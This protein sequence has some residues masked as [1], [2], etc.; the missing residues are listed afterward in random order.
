MIHRASDLAAFA[1]ALLRAAGL[2]GDRTRV[3][4]EVLVEADLLGHTTHGLDML[5]PYLGDLD[6]GRMARWGEPTTLL[7]LP[8]LRPWAERFGAPMMAS[9]EET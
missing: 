5:A 8:R 2:A 9:K 7:D 1:T 6:S 3:V 4:A